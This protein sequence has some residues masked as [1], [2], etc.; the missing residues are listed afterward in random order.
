M[1]VAEIEGVKPDRVLR[2]FCGANASANSEMLRAGPFPKVM[3]D[4]LKVDVA[5]WV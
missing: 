1:Q 3:R 2:M 5:S 4:G